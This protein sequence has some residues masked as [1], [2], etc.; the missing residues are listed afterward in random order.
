MERSKATYMY[1]SASIMPV[2]GGIYGEK[3]F[4]GEVCLCRPSLAASIGEV[5]LLRLSVAI[6]IRSNAPLYVEV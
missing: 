6:S 3:Q 4:Y 1:R 2:D 5:I